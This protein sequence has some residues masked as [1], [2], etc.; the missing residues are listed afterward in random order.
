[1]GNVRLL[2]NNIEYVPRPFHTIVLI[3]REQMGETAGGYVILR[4]GHHSLTGESGAR[5]NFRVFSL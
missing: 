5:I 2:G 4:S 1:M 3:F